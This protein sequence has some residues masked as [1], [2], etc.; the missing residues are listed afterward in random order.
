MASV[1]GIREKVHL[2]I[3]DS[4]FVEPEKQLREVEG[5]STLKFFVNVQGKNKLET[6]LQSASLLPHYNTFEARAMRVVISDLPPAFP[7]G[8]DESAPLTKGEAAEGFDVTD[9]DGNAIDSTGQI[10]NA[11]GSTFDPDKV[12]TADLELDLKR[13]VE[14]LKEARESEDKESTIDFD[15]DAV[16]LFAEDNEYEP[17]D[18]FLN[19]SPVIILSVADLEDLIDS[20]EKKAPPLEQIRPNDGAGNLIG[21]FV[22][23]TVTTLF[24]GEKIMIEMP[25][26]F[27]PGGAGPY[28]LGSQ[29]ISHGEPSPLATFRFADPIFI[30]RQQNFRVEIDIPDSD[31]HKEIQ[32]IYGPFFVWVVLDGYMTRDVQ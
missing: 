27:F 7:D 25:T 31:T 13:L 23:N 29:V 30:D 12:V 2:P 21:K 10:E 32:K 6:N 9:E 15:D 19:A 1:T 22:Y 20:L 14:L 26:Y 8:E 28:S 24:V 11:D 3:Y 5:G 16:T 18:D 17:V 4:V